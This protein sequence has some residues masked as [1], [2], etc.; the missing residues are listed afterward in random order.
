MALMRHRDRVGCVQRSKQNK[1]RMMV[2]TC[3]QW[4]VGSVDRHIIWAEPASSAPIHQTL[5]LLY[6][7]FGAK[8]V[9]P[10]IFSKGDRQRRIIQ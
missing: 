9:L 10:L 3:H 7:G 6:T 4:Q 5:T 1:T 2:I 8:Q